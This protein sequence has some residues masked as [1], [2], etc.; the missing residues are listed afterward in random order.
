MGKNINTPQPKS[1]KDGTPLVLTIAG[2]DSSGGAGIQGDIKSIA[3]NGAFG[4]SVLTAV[5]A[6]NSHRVSATHELPLWIIQGQFETLMADF[7][8][9]AVKTGMLTSKNIVQ[10]VVRL[11]KQNPLPNFVL[12]PVMRSKD[13]TELLSVD[14]IEALKKELIPLSTL[15]TPNIPEAEVLLGKQ[16]KTL[17]E[18]EK[19]AKRLLKLGGQAVLIKGGHLHES[20]GCDVL[21]DGQGITYFEGEFI[22]T[23]N[24]HGTGCTYASAIAAHLAVGKALIPAISAAKTFLTEAIRHGLSIGKGH[25]PTNPFYLLK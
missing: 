22:D 5:T 23:P 24:T 17:S 25:G 19:A 16:I 1:G 14:A 2:S 11:L 13:G 7:K 21:F 18:A 6:Q 15:L 20:P 9:D 10:C 4:L 8:P 3:A 12:D